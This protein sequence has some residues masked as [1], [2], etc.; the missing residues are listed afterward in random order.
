MLDVKQ[1]R[2]DFPILNTRQHGC[3]LI[4]LDNAAT[5]QMPQPVLE[6]L[7]SHYHS[8]NGN[9]H[10]GVH[11]LSQKSTSATERARERI[12]A[13]IGAK[14]E[15][16]IFTAGTTDS[17]NMLSQMLEPT[18][19][20]GQQII[21]S[22]MEHHS[23]LIPWQ[24]L[25]QRTGAVL[26]I[27]HMDRNCDLDLTQLGQLLER[28][29]ALVA[30][31][32]VSNVLGTVN[33][34]GEITMMSHAA[35]AMTVLD[36]AQAMKLPEIDVT[37]VDCDFLAFS[38]H[39][40]GAL[41]GIGVL[42]GKNNILSQLPPVRF[43]GGMIRES[44]YSAS[45]YGG[46]PQRFEAGTPNYVGAISLG[47]AMEYLQSVGRIELAQQEQILTVLL[48]KELA[49]IPEVTVIRT[50][51]RRCGVVSFVVPGIHPFDL[52]AML[53]SQGI[54]VRTGHLCAQPLVNQLGYDSV[55]RVSPAFYNTE[56]ECLELISALKRTIPLLKGEWT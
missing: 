40:L 22:A 50:P 44:Q 31:T 34:V 27:L 7:V 3:P 4:Y 32:W 21:V 6:Q 23:N 56:Q 16:I 39:K 53:D 37:A 20:P 52:G 8:Q 17:L 24:E 55:I 48:R 29:T 10:R 5:M 15:E 18:I 42:Y 51:N 26:T 36:G 54:A 19:R 13:Y 14:A 49:T 43:G 11:S 12:A 25:C 35:G 33:P 1:I 46:V 38:G 45:S 2:E 30:V 47:C 28:D 9:V 41:T